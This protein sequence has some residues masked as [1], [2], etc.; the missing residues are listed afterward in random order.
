M[1]HK[2]PIK[3]R[4]LRDL[5]FEKQRLKYDLDLNEKMMLSSIRLARET[6]SD[7]LRN[8]LEETTRKVL[9]I[10]IFRLIRKKIR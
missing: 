8:T 7:S 1:K 9:Y 3:L 10:A 5:Q 4:N 2:R 6:F